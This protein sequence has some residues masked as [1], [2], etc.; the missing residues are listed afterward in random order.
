MHVFIYANY[1]M[2]T[3]QYFN[4]MQLPTKEANGTGFMIDDGRLKNMR[5]AEDY[6]YSSGSI[7]PNQIRQYKG[8]KNAMPDDFANGQLYDHILLPAGAYVSTYEDSKIVA[9]FNFKAYRDRFN[10]LNDMA[11][12]DK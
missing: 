11:K 2:A 6:F 4:Q 12:G 9:D 5:P 8:D 3:D 1:K 7:D 10:I